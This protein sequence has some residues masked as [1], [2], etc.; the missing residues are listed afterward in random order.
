[1]HKDC[2]TCASI[3]YNDNC[4]PSLSN[5]RLAAKIG[6]SEAS[7][8]RHRAAVDLNDVDPFFDVPEAIITSRGTSRRLA[9]GS[10]EKITYR[11]QDKAIYEALSYDDIERAIENYTPQVPELDYGPETA[12]LCVA[13]LQVG[14]SD[15]LGGTPELIE[16][17]NRSFDAFEAYVLAYPVEHIVIGD[18]GDVIENFTNT[19]QQR[20]T[21]DIDLTTQVRT[22]RRLLLEAIKRF[23]PLAPTL[24]YVAV[25]SNHCQVRTGLGNKSAAST[26][27][28]DWGL[29]IAQQIGDVLRESDNPVFD[30]V[31]IAGPNQ[32]EEALTVNASG[33]T[34][35]FVH[36]HQSKDMGKWWQGQSHGRRSNLHNADILLHGHWHHFSVNQSGDERWLIGAPTSDSGSA[37]FTQQTGETS[38][39][40]MLMFRT[41]NGMWRD[42]KIA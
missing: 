12:V 10:W 16:R 7:I 30:G 5:V 22:A 13:D 23:A 25:P 37:W 19:N 41:S 17:V 31:T 18:L 1:M 20:E 9:D 14:K 21:N 6:T 33:T 29:E 40:G 28:N 2:A 35:G 32:L 34:L 39:P 36:G 38:T 11:P 3:T 24:T 42:I 15:L 26:V 4:N 8:R 27:Q